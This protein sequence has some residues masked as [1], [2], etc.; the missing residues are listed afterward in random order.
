MFLTTLGKMSITRRDRGRR[1]EFRPLRISLYPAILLIVAGCSHALPSIGGAPSTPPVRE[2]PWRVPAG[3]VPAEPIPDPTMVAVADTIRAAGPLVLPQVVDL[4]LRSNPLTQLSWAQA[5]AGA[6]QYGAAHAALVPTVDATSN[7]VNTRT[8][9][10][11]GASLRSTITPTASLSYLLFDF[12]GRSGNIAAARAAAVALDLTHNATLQDVALQAEA[13][14]FNYQATRGLLVAAQLALAEADT[15]LVSAQQRNRAGV[16]T[17]SDVLQAEVLR[18]QAQLDLETAEGNVQTAR[19][20]L[21]VAMGLPANARFELAS[22]SDSM[23]V[24]I[25]SAG[26]DTLIDRALALRPDLAAVRVQIQQAQAQVRVAKSAERPQVILGA[27]L[28]KTFSNV[29]NFVGLNYGISLGVQ[30][31]IFNLA[32]NY[33]VT[34]AE[35][36]VEAANARASL[37]RI[38]VGQQVYS[39]YYALQTATQRTLTSNVLLTSATRNEVAARARYRAGVAT[40]L[41]LTTAQT[42]LANARAQQAQARW[43]WATALAQ[44]SHDVGVLGP[45]GQTL[46]LGDSTGVRR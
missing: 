8:T 6:A 42:A 28:G 20:T 30:I 19:G 22:V 5:R 36:Q 21:A 15:N 41:E 25:T 13:S 27:N 12:G 16:A 3:V 43:V 7:I 37:L 10:Q 40:I 39:A 1:P 4:A 45:R 24:A 18:A 33:N 29:T 9:S 31:P 35:A 38:Q 14:Y 26:V 17:I 44:L 2:E 46:P 11:T 34:A 23:P 32:R